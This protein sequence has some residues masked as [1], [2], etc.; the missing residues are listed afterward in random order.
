MKYGWDA[1]LEYSTARREQKVL[2]QVSR[3]G[4]P[5][6][7]LADWLVPQ[8]SRALRTTTVEMRG[9]KKSTLISLWWI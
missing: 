8:D 6:A 9:K 5:S 4:A 1:A 7:T 3:V 2:A